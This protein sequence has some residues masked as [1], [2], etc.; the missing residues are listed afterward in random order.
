MVVWAQ[1]HLVGAGRERCRSPASSAS[2]PIAA[3]RAFQD[4]NGPARR[5]RD[6]HRHL[7]VAAPLHAVPAALGGAPGAHEQRR[8][9]EPRAAARPAAVGLAA[10]PRLRDKTG[11]SSVSRRPAGALA[12]IAM[13]AS[14]R[15]PRGR[16]R[17]PSVPSR[18]VSLEVPRPALPLRD[19]VLGERRRRGGADIGVRV[20]AALLD[21]RRQRRDD[22][23]RR[24][25]R[26]RANCDA[27]RPAADRRLHRHAD[28]RPRGRPAHGPA[29]H[30]IPA[31]LRLR[32]RRRGLLL[33]RRE[34]DR[35]RRLRRSGRRRRQLRLR[36]RP[37]VRPPRR[38]APRHAAALRRAINWGTERWAS[39]EDVCQGQR[40]GAPLPRRRGHPL[41]RGPGRGLRRGL[42]PHSLPGP[43]GP[44]RYMPALRADPGR[45]PGD[46]RRHPFALA[47]ADQL[48]ARRA[49]AGQGGGRSRRVLST[50]LDGMVSLRP[51][52]L[53]RH[54]Y[55]LA[56][57][58]RAGRLLRRSRH[59]LDPSD[60][61]RLHRLR[62]APPPP[63]DHL[64]P[65]PTEGPFRLQVQRP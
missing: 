62:P 27:D 34:Q 2:R 12:G 31:R 11:P 44:W 47:G 52:R 65:P 29:R 1:E 64:H 43:A 60:Q 37:R 15:G 3:V 28:P 30:R 6:R 56:L 26:L 10:R 38:P 54:G 22:R 53:R 4:A 48:H 18:R 24:H 14:P 23:R 21:R 17:R 7:G 39:V 42:R 32:L 57:R 40:A 59:G 5:R 50:P 13:I 33:Q 58:S 55:E 63:R 36:A 49:R 51:S 45:V 16:G 25:R 35:H 9:R 46:P 41:L 61:P 8:L 19:V 20:V